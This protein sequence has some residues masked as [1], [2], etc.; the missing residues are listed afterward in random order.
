MFAPKKIF[1]PI[2]FS[3]EGQ[4]E[5]A[6]AALDSALSLAAR[7]EASLVVC[8]SMPPMLDMLGPDFSGEA[9]VALEK[10]ARQAQD[11]VEERLEQC[12][13]RLQKDGVLVES[14]LAIG[15]EGV[16]K[17]LVRKSEELGADLVVLPSHGRMGIKRLFLGS[18][19]ERVAHLSKIPVLLLKPEVSS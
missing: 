4:E 11:R 5:L 18:V 19:A 6:N 13:E 14:C 15:D 7:F 1:V 2:D 12:V 16:A 17:S 8:S 3:D 10:V 9:A